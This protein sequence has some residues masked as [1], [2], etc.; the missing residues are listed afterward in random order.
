LIKTIPT[1]VPP[2]HAGT[3]VRNGGIRG[4]SRPLAFGIVEGVA[5]PVS[6]P[7]DATSIGLSAGV[8]SD[9]DVDSI[10]EYRR[11]RRFRRRAYSCLNNVLETC[12]AQAKPRSDFF[13]RT[14]HG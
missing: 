2:G 7:F 8:I 6:F 13:N 9:I 4:T 1:L 5:A 3:I 11:K 12:V 10:E 14:A